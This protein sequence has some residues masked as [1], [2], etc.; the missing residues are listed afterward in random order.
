MP[1]EALV[2]AIAGVA[3][4]MIGSVVVAAG[5]VV[6]HRQQAERDRVL[7]QRDL[8][9]QY[10]IDAYRALEGV[11]NWPDVGPHLAPTFERAIADIQLFGTAEQIHNAQRIARDFAENR[12]CSYDDLL[13]LLRRDLR[14]ELGAEEVS[15]QLQ[16]LRMVF[17]SE[18]ASELPPRYAVPR[19]P[20]SNSD[21]QPS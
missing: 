13:R 9:L 14:R 21:V 16:F 12:Q 2:G 20:R 4:A 11:A 18:R 7:K 5:W 19:Q 1:S 10:L 15:D 8:R 6:A 17:P 3:A